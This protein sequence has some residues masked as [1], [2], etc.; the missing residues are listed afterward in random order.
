MTDLFLHKMAIARRN[1]VLFSETVNLTLRMVG[2]FGVG[3]LFP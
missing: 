3:E 1:S 2:V